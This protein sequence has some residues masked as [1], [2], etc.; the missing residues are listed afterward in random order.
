MSIADSVTPATPATNVDTAALQ[1]ALKAF[2]DLE[3]TAIRDAQRCK[4]EMG[5][6]N[7]YWAGLANGAER[8]MDNLRFALR[9][10]GFTDVYQRCY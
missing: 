4:Q 7:R 10:E 8:A 2:F 1:K 3:V 6:E 9:M 5:A